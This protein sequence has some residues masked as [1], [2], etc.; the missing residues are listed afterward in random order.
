MNHPPLSV[1]PLEPRRLLSAGPTA[2]FM[3]YVK[4]TGNSRTFAVLYDSAQPIDRATLDNFQIYVIGTNDFNAPAT[5][6][7][8]S[9]HDPGTGWVAQYRIDGIMGGAY[10]I[11]SPYQPASAPSTPLNP[12]LGGFIVGRKG[13]TIPRGGEITPAIEVV[14]TTFGTSEFPPEIDTSFGEVV[15]AVN[16]GGDAQSLTGSTG[17]A[18][19]FDSRHAQSLGAKRK[20]PKGARTGIQATIFSDSESL[21]EQIT[22]DNPIF[23][24]EIFNDNSST[25]TLEI[26]G[27]D[28][29]KRYRIQFLHGDGSGG[30]VPY[31]EASQN[32]TLPTGE[33]ATTSLLFNTSEEDAD[34]NTIVDI[35]GT[36]ALEYTMPN[37]QSRAASFSGVVIEASDLIPAT[38]RFVRKSVRLKGASQTFALAFPGLDAE[39]AGSLATQPIVVTGPRGFSAVATLLDLTSNDQGVVATYELDGIDVTGTYCISVN[40]Q[41]IARPTFFYLRPVIWE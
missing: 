11:K 19:Q 31:Q 15:R 33:N 32:F 17:I 14:G 25:L 10:T 37:S 24:T 1:E 13:H 2:T 26:T 4:G 23:E 29:A 28:P 27:L 30:E 39:T 35:S 9:R 22:G 41:I 5:F 18:V 6:L 16:F 21:F 38:T 3:Q 8:A 36:T 20:H 7:G 40:G 34:S 12:D